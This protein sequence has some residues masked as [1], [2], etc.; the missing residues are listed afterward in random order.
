MISLFLSPALEQHQYI[1]RSL[2]RLASKEKQ[3]CCHSLVWSIVCDCGRMGSIWWYS[4]WHVVVWYHHQAVERGIVSHSIYICTYLRL[5]WILMIILIC[6]NKFTVGF[7]SWLSKISHITSVSVFSVYIKLSVFSIL[8]PSWHSVMCCCI[9]VLQL[10]LP[11]KYVAKRR[12]HSIS[13]LQ[14]GPHCMWLI[15]FGGFPYK[16]DTVIIELSEY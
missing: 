7:F 11:D 1:Y 4:E 6:D 8:K 14:L 3:S 10:P 2:S 9:H 12:Y 16:A 13:T 15:L 5:K